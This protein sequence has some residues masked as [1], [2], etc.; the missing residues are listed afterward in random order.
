MGWFGGEL[1]PSGHPAFAF[2]A[3]FS[4]TA[5]DDSPQAQAYDEVVNRPH[6]AKWTHELLGGAAAYE[7]AKAYED[8]VA[9]N[10]KLPA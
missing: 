7:A 2:R 4:H 8:H 6:E 5:V 10:G 9:S 1:H 3:D